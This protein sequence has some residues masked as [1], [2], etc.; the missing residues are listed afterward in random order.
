MR[1]INALVDLDWFANVGQ[2]ILS[3]NESVIPIGNWREAVASCSGALWEDVCMEARN[4]LSMHLNDVCQ[5]EFQTWNEVVNNSKR[6]LSES[7]VRMRTK[8]DSEGLPQVVADCVEWDTIH[9]VVFEHF[10]EW[11]PPRFF[12]HLLRIY[13]SGHFPCGWEGS[14]PEGKLRVF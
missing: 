14:W 3:T 7:W 1:I 4:D 11:S 12:E 6:E 8:L 5:T 2:L 10:A 9:A 13:Q